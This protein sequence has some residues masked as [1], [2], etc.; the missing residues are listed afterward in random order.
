MSA[1]LFSTKKKQIRDGSC[2]HKTI[3]KTK[4]FMSFTPALSL[5][6]F[7]LLYRELNYIYLIAHFS[8]NEM[9]NTLANK[10]PASSRFSAQ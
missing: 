9:R 8:T 1:H 2:F 4:I 10:M 7:S 6:S 3:T 5:F